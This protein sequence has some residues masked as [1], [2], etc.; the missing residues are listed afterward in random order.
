MDPNM[1]LINIDQFIKD[2]RTGDIVDQWC[3]HLFNWIKKGGF[4]PDWNKYP[5]G[6]LYYHCREVHM[7]G[8]V[9]GK[10]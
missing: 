9:T 3:W 1:C 10:V 7:L 8:P 4:E 5:A 6:N 2:Q